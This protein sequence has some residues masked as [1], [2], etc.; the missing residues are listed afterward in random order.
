MLLEKYVISS[1]IFLTGGMGLINCGSNTWINFIILVAITS[2]K[3]LRKYSG[4]G[5]RFCAN[6]P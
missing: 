4:R 2:S 5:R 1:L 6:I 3:H